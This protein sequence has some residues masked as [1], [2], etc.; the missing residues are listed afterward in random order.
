MKKFLLLLA[1]GIIIFS[2]GACKKKEEQVSKT[3][4]AE[5]PILD[6]PGVSPHSG[7]G[8]K[9]QFDVVVP[10]DVEAGWSAV[11]LLVEDKELTKQEEFTVQIG[12]EFQIPDSTLMV[13]VAY[14]LPDF[15]M[16]GPVITSASNTLNNPA[17]GIVISEDG[18]QV[19][20]ETGKVGWLYEKFPTIHPFQHSRFGL[21]LK[22]GVKK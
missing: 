3:P 1:I 13:K 20:P 8:Q 16:S 21:T 5:G 18:K 9:T 14:F 6:T 12:D 7:T 10:P 17:V 15:K 19:F 4:L 2:L 22:E 11:T